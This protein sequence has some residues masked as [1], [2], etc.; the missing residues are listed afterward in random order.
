MNL[1]VGDASPIGKAKELICQKARR[2]KQL[3]W[4]LPKSISN[5]L[6]TALILRAARNQWLMAF[7]AHFYGHFSRHLVV[8]N[9]FFE[10]SFLLN[11]THLYIRAK[12]PVENILGERKTLTAI[13]DE[14]YN[15][16]IARVRNWVETNHQGCPGWKDWQASSCRKNT[17]FTGVDRRTY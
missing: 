12:S 5:P 7:P 1:V 15:A 4:N 16:T 3:V 17:P 8:Q 14:S 2:V 9:I 10:V 6:L 11:S 13:N